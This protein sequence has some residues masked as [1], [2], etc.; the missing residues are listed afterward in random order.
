MLDLNTM[1]DDVLGMVKS[2]Y[3]EASTIIRLTVSTYLDQFPA[4]E[5]ADAFTQRG[6]EAVVG[7]CHLFLYFD[8]AKLL[9]PLSPLMQGDSDETKKRDRRK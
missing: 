6:V 7:H 2:Q 4:Q 1:V 8:G 3:S 5:V 9:I